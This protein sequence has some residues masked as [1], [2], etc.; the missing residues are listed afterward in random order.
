MQ[1]FTIPEILKTR[2]PDQGNL[3]SESMLGSLAVQFGRAIA[4]RRL[5]DAIGKLTT[6]ASDTV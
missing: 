4:A 1:H 5:R 3:E 2:Q 6:R